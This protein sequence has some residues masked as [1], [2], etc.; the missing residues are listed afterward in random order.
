[1]ISKSAVGKTVCKLKRGKAPGLEG[2][3]P[4]NLRYGTDLLFEHI[5]LFQ[6]CVDCGVVPSSFCAGVLSNIP[7]NG[8][9]QNQCRGYRPITVSSVFS[10]AL[11]LV[12]LP[13]IS[14]KCRLDYR[15]FGLHR[16]LSCAF[17]H[18][19]LQKAIDKAHRMGSS[20]FIRSV[21]ISNAFDSAVESEVFL[22]LLEYGMNGHVIALLSFGT[23][24]VLLKLD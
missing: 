20:L 10:K 12:F 9:N 13:E 3:C 18:R 15:Q 23:Q 21:D 24:A 19:L 14:G 7:Q 2:I 11:E 1:M 16:N 17:V 5:A 22:K 4:D 6:M 8:K